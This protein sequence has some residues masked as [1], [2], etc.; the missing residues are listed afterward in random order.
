MYYYSI[1]N[2]NGNTVAARRETEDY[3]EALSMA[4]ETP[5]SSVTTLDDGWVIKTAV[6]SPKHPVPVSG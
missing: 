5:H 6:Y 1:E 3:S 4:K 2:Y